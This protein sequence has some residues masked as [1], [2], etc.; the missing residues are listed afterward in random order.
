M[1][2]YNYLQQNELMHY[3]KKG[4]KWG[5]RSVGRAQGRSNNARADVEPTK[6]IGDA[7]SN[8]LAKR[9]AKK[10]NHA[11]RNMALGVAALAAIATVSI[12]AAKSGANVTTGQNF[13]KNFDFNKVRIYG[14]DNMAKN[15]AFN[16]AKV[17]GPANMAK[18]LAFNIARKP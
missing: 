9:A 1:W 5:R 17:N 6:K 11:K 7:Y 15:L 14:P 10:P 13:M 18:N 3:G 8:S 4:M 2:Q 16:T 12:V